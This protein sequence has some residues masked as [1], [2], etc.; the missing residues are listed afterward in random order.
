MD[1]KDEAPEVEPKK[2]L[3]TAKKVKVIFVDEIPHGES[4]GRLVHGELVLQRG[5]EVEVSAAEAKA[6]KE[7]FGGRYVIEEVV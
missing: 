1:L 5:D 2:D 7:T 3:K 4:V 6:I